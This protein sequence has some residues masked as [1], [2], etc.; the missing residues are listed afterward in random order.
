LPVFIAP[1]ALLN[2]PRGGSDNQQEP[3]QGIFLLSIRRQH[4]LRKLLVYFFG[5]GVDG[6]IPLSV[7]ALVPGHT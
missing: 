1:Y 3:P 7:F 2:I 6:I 4:Q 5:G